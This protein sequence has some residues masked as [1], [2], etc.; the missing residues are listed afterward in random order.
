M[1]NCNWYTWTNEVKSL[2]EINKIIEKNAVT[3]EEDIKKAPYST[4]TS[5]VKYIDYFYLKKFLEPYIVKALS[6]NSD[7]FGYNLF[8]ISPTKV[9]NI[10][11]YSINKKYEWHTDASDNPVNDIKLT[12]LINIS[13]KNYEGGEFQVFKSEHPETITHFSKGGDMILLNPS[14]LHNHL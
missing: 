14:V 6:V 8:N 4:K 9:L 7:Y 1:I 13:E 3:F 11:Y 10:N 2:K 12:L 5:M